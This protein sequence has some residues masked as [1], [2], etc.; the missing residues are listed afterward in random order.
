MLDKSTKIYI[1]GHQ[2]L[3]GSALVTE[4][5][6]KGYQHLIL[7]TRAECDLL[8]VDHVATLF[9]TEKPDVVFLAAAKVGGILANHQFPA[10]FIYQNL[11]I[12]LNVIHQAFLNGVKRLVF[13]GSSCI[14]PKFCPQPMQEA[15]LLSGDLEP[16]NRPY[17]IAK[18]AGIELCWSYNRQ[19]QTQYL[20]V[21]PTNLFGP[22]DNY[23]LHTSHVIPALIR[24]I[25]AAKRTHS[26]QV[27]LW[28]TGAPRREFLYSPDLAAACVHLME[29]SDAKLHSVVLNTPDQPPLI[30]VG[31]GSD[32]TI[33]ELA[34]LLADIIGFTGKFVF[35]T[36][37]P[38]GTPQKLLDCR[39]IHT[40]G[41][42]PRYDLRAALTKTYAN[43]CEM[44]C[45]T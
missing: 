42:K 30:N 38:D 24:K 4:L 43:F 13:L 26:Q 15:H 29:L 27:T 18:I 14:Y 2:G 35:D 7:R 6:E 17:A 45:V 3:V 40:L 37:L 33:L 39:K 23:D 9:Q 12:E 28:G 41:W 34:Q 31:Y 22:H 11:Q 25:D 16:T 5:A 20:A 1:A 8:N 32:V 44:H 10:D 19:Y 21:M 36:T